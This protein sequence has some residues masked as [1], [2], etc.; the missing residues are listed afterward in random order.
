M[1]SPAPVRALVALFCVTALAALV[2]LG[3]LTVFMA[4][5]AR[6]NFSAFP[7][8]NWEVG[9]SCVSAYFV[10]AG[11]A[12]EGRSVYRDELYTA[13]N[14]DG[15]G[16]RKPRMLGRF[17]ID[18][19]EYPP[20]F[21]LFPL[22][23]H[24]VLPGF[25]AFRLLWFVLNAVGVA[26]VMVRVA[27]ALP[28]PAAKRAL[29][30]APLV[31][32]SPPTLSALQKGNVQFLIVALA[33]LAMLLFERRRFAAGGA[34][35]A[36][37]IVSKLFPGLLLVTLIVRRQFRAVAWTAAMGALLV[38]LSLVV[39]GGRQ[40]V[41]FA[42]HLPGLLGGEAFPAFRNP[43]AIAINFSIPG[44]V[45]KLKVLGLDGLSFGASKI[46]GWIYTLVV[47]VVV[48]TVSR[49]PWSDEDKPALWLA[50]L[51]LST[52]RS[53]FLPQAYAACPPVW[54]VTLLAARQPPT[55]KTLLWTL[56]AWLA[57]SIYWP[58]DWPLGPRAL[59]LLT[60]VPQAATVAV[61]AVA[62]RSPAPPGS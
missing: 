3:R 36:F 44:L 51:I 62:L 54:L 8:S 28:P 61:A 33:M 25:P 13:P 32:I 27:R 39:V 59:A 46:V 31:W 24:A 40:Y 58:L 22:A 7:S 26:L 52:L 9:H 18:V 55:V 4:D 37:A 34:L 35:L 47:L 48:V 17:G 45:F 38:V 15:K 23:L 16:V 60:L 10:A 41:G 21:L 57:L 29:L 53:P 11:A 14:D 56:G 30:L 50:I 43:S 12:R 6:P 2:V 20:P 42:N 19:Y 1:P 49:R 5:D